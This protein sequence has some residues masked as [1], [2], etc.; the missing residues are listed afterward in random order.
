[1]MEVTHSLIE[2]ILLRNLYPREEYIFGTADLTGLLKRILV[3]T[4]ME[5]P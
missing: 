4:G 3:S 1:M 2:N 5:Y